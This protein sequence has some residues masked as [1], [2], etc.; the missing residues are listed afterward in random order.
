MAIL[1]VLCGLP[2]LAGA[3]VGAALLTASGSGPFGM[4]WSVL[5]VG[6]AIGAATLL[7]LLL[8]RQRPNRRRFLEAGLH[9]FARARRHGTA[10]TVAILDVDHFKS[11]N[12]THGHSA[13][14]LAHV[15]GRSRL[16]PR[17]PG[18]VLCSR[19]SVLLPGRQRRP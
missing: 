16:R 2:P 12:D 18:I 4:T 17:R 6:D 11:V 10:T 15:R 3:T 1:L 13:R 9:E 19:R 14:S 8:L 7:P 5:V